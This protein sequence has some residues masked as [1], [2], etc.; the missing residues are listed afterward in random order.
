MRVLFRAF[1]FVIV[2][3]YVLINV[4]SSV[5]MGDLIRVGVLMAT[6][7]ASCAKKFATLFVATT[8]KSV[9]R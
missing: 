1:E 2:G 7:K 3:I 5:H 9:T 8:D 4:T 6:L